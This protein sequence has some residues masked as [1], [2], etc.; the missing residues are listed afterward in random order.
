MMEIVR[1]KE[2]IELIVA[3]LGLAIG[4]GGPVEDYLVAVSRG[5]IQ[6]VCV[7]QDRG[8]FRSLT[9]DHIQI[10]PGSVMFRE[11]PDFIVAGEIVRTSRMYAMSVSPLPRQ[12]IARISPRLEKLLPRGAAG[13]GR[14]V[15]ASGRSRYEEASQERREEKSKEGGEAKRGRRG[16]L[17]RASD[18]RDLPR[19]F[20]NKIKIGGQVFD[21]QVEKNRK[22]V[23][24]AWS[25]LMAARDHVDRDNLALYKDLRGIVR[26]G[27]RQLLE[28]EKLEVI[29]KVA[30][31]LD[32][33]GDLARPW[34]R[35]VNLSSTEEQ[36]KLLASLDS[37]LQ[38]AEWRKE[39]RELGF[40]TLF[41][42]GEGSYW[43]RVS[44]GFHTALNESLASL[45][46]LADELGEDAPKEG[47][48]RVSVLYRRLQSFFE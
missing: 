14:Q 19:D 31:W 40:V 6:F 9:A 26:V 29:L 8:L 12:L 5:L 36:G 16:K 18:A 37:V 46:S 45:E 2:Q 35:N 38:V 39:S 24:L 47:K 30:H 48:E 13:Q 10:H 33:D 22:I 7:R 11:N 21:I 43:F 44:R 32:P 23:Q 1:V 42:D 41:T 4:S 20:S 15:G 3:G 28:G 17:E 25:D 27:H 34:P